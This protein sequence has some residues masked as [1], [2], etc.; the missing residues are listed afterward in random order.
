[1][2]AEGLFILED[3]HNFREDYNK[4]LMQWYKNFTENWN[5]HYK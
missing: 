4:T 3:W 2:A 5:K 1:K